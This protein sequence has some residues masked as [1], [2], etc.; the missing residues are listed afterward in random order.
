LAIAHE[1]N[2]R[3]LLHSAELIADNESWDRRM[4]YRLRRCEQYAAYYEVRHNNPR[5]G[6][7]SMFTKTMIALLAA[8]VLNVAHVSAQAQT[9][10]GRGCVSMEE[11][12]RSAF[13]AYR[14]C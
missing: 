3:A 9:N 8:L 7:T 5:A 4:I 12:A 14:V 11:G 1:R 10:G 6:A 13:P 2:A